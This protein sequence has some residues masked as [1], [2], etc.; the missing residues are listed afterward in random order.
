[1]KIDFL[2]LISRIEIEVKCNKKTK[3]AT[4]QII[5]CV[6]FQHVSLKE[7][8][9]Q[10]LYA[11]ELDDDSGVPSDTERKPLKISLTKKYYTLFFISYTTVRNL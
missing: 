1:M 10:P 5:C 8:T 6:L 3:S 2:I 4:K 9:K 11:I 7:C